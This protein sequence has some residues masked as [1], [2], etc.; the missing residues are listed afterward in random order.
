MGQKFWPIFYMSYFFLPNM[1]LYFIQFYQTTKAP[2]IILK[3]PTSHPYLQLM[4]SKRWPP[5]T[6]AIAS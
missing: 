6:S 3:K 5:D 1:P 4:L 2:V